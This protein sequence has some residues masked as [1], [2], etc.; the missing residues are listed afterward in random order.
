[1]S[2]S[3]N[4]LVFMCTRMCTK[5]SITVLDLHLCMYM[6]NRST[7]F[8][9]YCRL[10]FNIRIFISEGKILIDNFVV[11]LALELHSCW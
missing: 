6:L 5:L 9:N 4:F 11:V 10:F 1:M 3:S 7:M 2:L 8:I